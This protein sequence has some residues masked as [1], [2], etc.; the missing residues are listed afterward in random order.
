MSNQTAREAS[1]EVGK[2]HNAF[3]TSSDF[4]G[5]RNLQLLRSLDS[6]PHA[7]RSVGM[8]NDL[9]KYGYQHILVKQVEAHLRKCVLEATPQTLQWQNHFYS[10]LAF[11]RGTTVSGPVAFP[12]TGSDTD[13]ARSTNKALTFCTTKQG[14]AIAPTGRREGWRAQHSL[15]VHTQK[16]GCWHSCNTSFCHLTVSNPAAGDRLCFPYY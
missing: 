5:V 4:R 9:S 11:C 14:K 15:D 13:L 3:S 10:R 7:L 16:Q 12:I 2:V 8:Q 1:P 6:Q